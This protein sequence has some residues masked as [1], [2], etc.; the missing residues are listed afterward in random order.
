MKPVYN[1]VLRDP[2]K[3]NYV[4]E[5]TRARKKDHVTPVARRLGMNDPKR[6]PWAS[7]SS[8]WGHHRGP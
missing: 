6:T 7:T 8:G 4:K 3:V 1:R 2:L 5:V